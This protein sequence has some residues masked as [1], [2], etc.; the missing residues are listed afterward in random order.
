MKD[1]APESVVLVWNTADDKA[2][3]RHTGLDA[4][5]A[6]FTK[7][8]DDLGAG[9]PGLEVPFLETDE[10]S[11]TVF[12]VWV[13]TNVPKATDTFIFNDAG[14]IITQNIQIHVTSKASMVFV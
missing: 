14:K 2:V 9:N 12:L 10:T 7:L 6:M 1:Y 11:K 3:E 5:R 8:F 4:I 13:S